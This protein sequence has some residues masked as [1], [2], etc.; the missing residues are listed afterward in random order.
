MRKFK[1]IYIEPPFAEW[2]FYRTVSI[3]LWR[4][5]EPDC[6]VAIVAPGEWLPQVFLCIDRWGIRY[7]NTYPTYRNKFLVTGRYGS[8]PTPDYSKSP[9]IAL[10]ELEG[11]RCA[12]NYHR[13]RTGWYHWHLHGWPE[14][15]PFAYPIRDNHV[16]VNYELASKVQEIRELYLSSQL[17]KFRVGDLINEI[18]ARFTN[19]DAIEL[20]REATGLSTQALFNM[21]FI[22]NRVPLQARLGTAWISLLKAFRQVNKGYGHGKKT[23]SLGSGGNKLADPADTME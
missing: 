10:Q 13:F 2:G 8:P 9:F 7:E 3:P 15:D 12:M 22:A 4:I 11:P 16:E 6:N 20:A 14:V 23:S 1:S 18:G 17:W 5:A 21:A 19:D